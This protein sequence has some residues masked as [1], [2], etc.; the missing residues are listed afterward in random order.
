MDLAFRLHCLGKELSN[1]SLLRHRDFQGHLVTG[2]NSGTHWVK[3]MI[4]L[5]LA[6][7]FDVA[8]PAFV[9]ADA[10]DDFMGHPKKV[11]PQPGMPRLASSH[12]I[13][14]LGYESALARLSGP[15]PPVA[16]LVRDLRCVLISHF[17]KWKDTYG[18]D[19]LTYLQGRKGHRG[20]RCD[21]WWYMQFLNRWGDAL[22]A[23]PREII[24]LKYEGMRENP[25]DGLG[26]ILF[27]FGLDIEPEVIARAIAASSKDAMAEKVDP[28]FPERVIDQREDRLERYFNGE[29]DV[30]FKATLRENLRHSFGY[31]YGLE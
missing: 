23:R 16:L 8:P 18:V 26:R 11:R 7:A 3:Y 17:E 4:C 31:D 14:G 29:A 9:N 19:W 1:Y 5:A 27:H 30:F 21:I 12:T 13:P 6:E 2:K 20:F 28:D 25:A 10:T 15:V 22:R 24:L